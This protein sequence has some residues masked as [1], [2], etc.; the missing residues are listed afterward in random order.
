LQKAARER[1]SRRCVA[2]ILALIRSKQQPHEFRAAEGLRLSVEA[3]SVASARDPPEASPCDPRPSV[4]GD[5][6]GLLA[7]EHVWQ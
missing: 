3:R 5:K 1:G 6:A 4:A 7:F 2:C